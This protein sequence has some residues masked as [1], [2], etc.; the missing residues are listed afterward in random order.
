[1][2]G[3]RPHIRA[4]KALA[5]AFAVEIGAARD[6]DVK[7]MM[8]SFSIAYNRAASDL[9]AQHDAEYRAPENPAPPE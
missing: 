1:M 3:L 2:S 7:A 8:C 9:Q 6:P 5:D 4:A